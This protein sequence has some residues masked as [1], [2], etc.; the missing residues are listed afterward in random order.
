PKPVIGQH[1][2]WL[3]LN[4]IAPALGLVDADKLM[5]VVLYL[6]AECTGA[7]DTGLDLEILELVAVG[8]LQQAGAGIE[9]TGVR[10][11]ARI[12]RLY[13]DV[14]WREDALTDEPRDATLRLRAVGKDGRNIADELKHAVGPATRLQHRTKKRQAKALGVMLVAVEIERIIL[15]EERR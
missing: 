4:L 12:R 6:A 2:A 15:F 9:P 10:P 14:L 3:V 13:I 11:V 8:L 5:K 7:D 1:A